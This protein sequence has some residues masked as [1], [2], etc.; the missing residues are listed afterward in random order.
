M[1][2]KHGF[3]Y[4]KNIFR[5]HV[6]CYFARHTFSMSRVV[7]TVVSCLRLRL[8]VF[9]ADVLFFFYLNFFRKFHDVCQ[10]VFQKT[11]ISPR[12]WHLPE[13]FSF[14]LQ[15]TLGNFFSK[16]FGRNILKKRNLIFLFSTF[17][18]KTT[19]PWLSN[20]T[21][22]CSTHASRASHRH[23]FL[24]NFCSQN[25]RRRITNFLSIKFFVF[26]RFL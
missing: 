23:L 8:N 5:H 26:L 20:P 4:F 17:C 7:I 14:Q 13:L 12:R 19:L 21:Y 24:F 18:T 9:N 15:R 16:F 10:N 6:P 22:Y 1:F 25:F 3:T 2:K 11:L